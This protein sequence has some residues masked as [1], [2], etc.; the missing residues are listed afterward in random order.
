MK[1]IRVPGPQQA[2]G[3]QAGNESNSR[4]RTRYAPHIP[5]PALAVHGVWNGRRC[6]L[7]CAGV[8][9]VPVATNTSCPGQMRFCCCSIPPFRIQ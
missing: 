8:A 6:P 4:S 9:H 1:R 2:E 3:R 7:P 5:A